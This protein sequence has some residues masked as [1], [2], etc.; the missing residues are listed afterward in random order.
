MSGTS[1]AYRGA[2]KAILAGLRIVPLVPKSKRPAEKG[3]Q[4]LQRQIT[5]I[6][7]L[8]AYARAHPTAN[9][10]VVTGGEA[11]LVVVD[12]DGKKGARA[13]ARLEK[14]YGAFPATVT[15][16]TPGGGRHIYF[17]AGGADI[18][19]SAGNLAPNTDVRGRGG[20]VVCTGSV[21][22]NGGIYRYAAGRALGEV[23]IASLPRWL[24]KKLKKRKVPRAAVPTKLTE[25]QLARGKAYAERALEV[26][27]SRVRNAPHG[28][29]NDTLNLASFRTGQFIP[30]GILEPASAK[31]VL[32][33]A[34][35]SAGHPQE[36][37]TATIESGMSAGAKQPR[38]LPFKTR[39]GPVAPGAKGSSLTKRL[40]QLGEDDLGNAERFVQR[41]GHKVM[42]TPGVGWLV[43]VGG[44]WTNDEA[45][46]RI[47]LAGEV[48]KA[49]R[50]EVA[51]IAD[52]G[53]K[54]LRRKFAKASRHKS[55]IDRMLQIV[56]PMVATTDDKLDADLW[57]LN[58]TNGTLDLRTGVLEQHNPADLITRI[59]STK[60]VPSAKA[61][62]FKK[63]L[64]QTCG[65][66]KDVIHFIQKAIGYSLTGDTTEQVLFF[67][68]GPGGTGKSTL[69]NLI[70]DLLSE[71]GVHTA[72]KTLL[73]KQFDNA[74][75]EDIARLKGARM[76]T[77]IE[78]NAN[79][80]LDEAKIKAMTGG[81][82]LVGRFMRQ[83]SFEYAPEFKLWFMANDMPRVRAT[84]DAIWRRLIVIP[85][86]CQ[87]QDKNQDKDLVKKLRA[88]FEGILAWAVRGALRWQKVGLADKTMFDVE[89]SRWREQ[90]NTVGRF[91]N[92]C[93]QIA[94]IGETVP[95]AVMFGRYS[96]WCKDNAEKP[97]T[98][99][100]FKARMTELNIAYGRNKGVRFWKGIKLIK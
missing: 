40:A 84:D 86:T 24:I 27:A 55:A 29:Q 4:Q 43:Y 38:A 60:Y 1:D 48:M 53:A 16:I 97:S 28:K 46:M 54:N 62:L 37:G 78:S 79:Q 39:T 14:K 45:G 13:L 51:H 18:G 66:N 90:S 15:V 98:I 87:V 64:R 91:F 71:Y 100:I 73:V 31:Q 88:E 76:V 61:N 20:L 85:F 58:V 6:R 74:I 35:C 32:S 56:Q 65:G 68:Y 83:N 52:G 44:R 69:A 12:P 10:G 96:Q 81:D 42:W 82:K 17:R 99:A 25:K 70:R 47:S 11:D 41:V 95:A 22:P 80:Q 21:H 63:F 3:W 72:T 8:K 5:T 7:A 92:E 59:C 33:T 30:H 9:F 2:K 49:I 57:L 93:C 67:I 19:N 34:A 89:K 36:E 94:P 26:E 75:P 50:K 77:A 23:E